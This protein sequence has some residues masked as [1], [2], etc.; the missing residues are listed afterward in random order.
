MDQA[1][2]TE[3]SARSA[4]LRHL[5]SACHA[6]AGRRRDLRPLISVLCLLALWFV[7]C[8]HLSSEWSVNDQY[9]YGWFVPFFAAIL[10]WL[11]WEQRPQPQAA[12]E[13][14]SSKLQAPNGESAKIRNPQSEIRTPHST[15]RNSNALV[16]ALLAI[17]ALV[18]LLPL[19]LFELANADWRPLAWVHT[20]LVVFLTLIYIWYVGGKPWLRHFAFPVAF[21]FVAVP[22]ISPIEQPVV[23]GLMRAV[24]AVAAE[25][26]TLFGIP[27][28][29]EGSLIR[30]P[31][32]L[33]GVNEACSGVRSLQTALMI[34]LLFGEL[35]RFDLTRRLAL[36]V[37][38]V[39][40]S[41]IANCGR[42]FFL[43][44][45]AA[46]NGVAAVDRWHDFAGYSI[47][48]LVFVGTLA[49]AALLSK[50][51]SLKAKVENEEEVREPKSELVTRQSSPVTPLPNFYFLP[52]TFYFTAALCWL[53]FVEIA[54]ASWYRAHEH[55]LAAG[56]R[57]SVH[58][59][60]TLPGLRDLKIDE[61]VRQT[62][63]FDEG[64]AA[65]WRAEAPVSSEPEARPNA[66]NTFN[67][68]LFFFRW[69]PGSGTVLRARAHRPDICLPSTGWEQTADHQFRRYDI[70]PNLAL[71][72]Q[73]LE[74][75]H[76]RRGPFERD[77]FA[78]AFFCLQ[79][80]NLRQTEART[81][82]S[83]ANGIQPDW[84]FRGRTRA[85]LNGVRNLGQQTMELVLMSPVQVS[86]G[87]AEE[88][89]AEL[90]PALIKV[91]R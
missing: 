40:L 47:V 49:A 41:L 26:A 78:H 18:L 12:A 32:G 33:V 85:V 16:A 57:W 44:W 4:S 34:G 13:V 9:S 74:F 23:Q 1:V 59:P 83:V 60:T 50:G 21:I 77:Q 52:S 17:P 15:I 67:Y 86:A 68:T 75:V 45:V 54:A 70:G 51:E 2:A 7:L 39:A 55:N 42:A 20:A 29:L 8:R 76:K 37:T 46:N 61:G 53:L 35:K 69:N 10:F 79:E 71:P 58:W 25:T 88:R 43:V 84:S 87:D 90:L 36:I 5:T 82:L 64:R 91:E 6:V 66:P 30:I 3:S 19:R 31:S 38:A 48:A 24:A 73:H 28:Q 27:A 89:F 62:L 80:D 56:T 72:F 65:R 22:W 14:P 11:R 81:D 63:R